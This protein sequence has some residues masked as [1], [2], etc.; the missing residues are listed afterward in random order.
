MQTNQPTGKVYS[1]QLPKKVLFGVKTSENVGLEA[2]AL[3]GKVALLVTDENMVKMGI[4]GKIEEAL[5]K[6]GLTVDVFNKVEPEPVIE[7]AETVAEAVRKRRY[8]IVVGVGGGSVLD[9]AKV[10]AIAL[11]NPNPMRNYVSV[12]LVKN[13]GVPSILLPTTSGT[14]SEVTNVAVVTIAENELKTS[15]ISP[16]M[17]GHVAIIDP[18]L[19][20]SLPPRLTASTGLDALSHALEAILSVNSNPITDAL[21]LQA[22]K[23][24]FNNLL[25]AYQSGEPESRYGMSLGSLMAG[26]AFGNAGV[27]LGHAAAYTFAVSHKV[28]HGVSCGL[29]LPYIFRFSAPA[30][31]WK[32]PEVVR[33]MNLDAKNL[34]PD[35]MGLVV[36]DSVLELMGELQMPKRLRDLGIPREAMSKL[37]DKLLTF[38]RLILRSPRQPSREEALRL[39]E[40]MW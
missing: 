15:I 16:N 11:T 4:S 33:V 36:S 10:A 37:A 32:I 20:Y 9:M 28:T 39:F 30:I 35:G 22:V 31:S 3:G 14:G 5:V 24:I 21:A 12:D 40:E 13:P 23:L 34:K 29:V 8:N 25:N 26:M 1:F 18:S 19:T 6:E 38:K 7:V 2:K 27:C 17:F